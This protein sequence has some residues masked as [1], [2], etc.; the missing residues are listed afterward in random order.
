[1]ETTIAKVITDDDL[2]TLEQAGIIPK[3]TP[4]EQVAVFAKICKEKG[5]SPFTKQIYLLPFKVKSGENW[6]TQYATIT[7]ID[8]YRAIAERTGRYAGNDDYRFDEG[9]TEFDCRNNKRKQPVTATATV[10]KLIGGQRVPHSAT[11]SWDSYYPG[12]KKGFNWMRMPFFMLGKV[13]EALALRKAFPEALGSIYVEEERG[14]METIPV[15]TEQAQ[16]TQEQVNTSAL[17]LEDFKKVVLET[18]TA[19]EVK[20]TAGDWLADATSQGLLPEHQKE[21]R[22]FI[23]QQYTEKK[24]K[25]ETGIPSK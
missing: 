24:T 8:G 10:Y 15:K 4:V 9:L 2:K 12:E 14:A 6:I 16:I 11:A 17:I 18:Q 25:N 1:M 13:A 22:N 23:N 7:G 21:L 20:N 5:L 19:V 3:N